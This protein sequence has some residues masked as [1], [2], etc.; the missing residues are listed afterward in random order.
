MQMNVYIISLPFLVL[1]CLTVSQIYPVHSQL[2]GYLWPFIV[3]DIIV[4]LI[5]PMIVVCSIIPLV[6]IIRYVTYAKLE[7]RRLLLWLLPFLSYEKGKKGVYWVLEDSFYYKIHGDF[8]GNLSTALLYTM[9]GLNFLFSWVYFVDDVFIDQM[10][11][12]NCNELTS[13]QKQNLYC[14]NIYPTSVY[15]NCT[16]NATY[17]GSL[18]CFEFKQ[19]G[20]NINVLQ[21]LVISVALYY[22][23]VM[24]TSLVLQAMKLLQKY[25][26]SFLW[27]A[28]IVTVGFFV[29]IYG[30]VHFASA[31][32]FNYYLNVLTLFQVL[33]ASVNIAVL[34]ILVAGGHLMQDKQQCYSENNSTN[35]SP[36]RIGLI[37]NWVNDSYASRRNAI[38]R[39][40]V[41]PNRIELISMTPIPPENTYSPGPISSHDGVSTF[42]GPSPHP[43]VA[44]SSPGPPTPPL[45]PSS[46]SNPPPMSAAPPSSHNPPQSP[47]SAQSISSS[48]TTTTNPAA[49]NNDN[50]NETSLMTSDNL[51]TQEQQQQQQQQQEDDERESVSHNSTIHQMTEEPHYVHA[52]IVDSTSTPRQLMTPSTSSVSNQTTNME[53]LLRASNRRIPPAANYVTVDVRED[54][55]TPPTIPLRVHNDGHPASQSESPAGGRK[56]TIV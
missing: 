16:A 37:E 14:F 44:A 27:P 24:L 51:P 4:A 54:Y 35:T 9:A 8:C 2:E 38:Y 53:T 32:Y 18:F 50:I 20:R 48:L 1:W 5:S 34:G 40:R 22:I 55:M 47:S 31:V 7:T 45:S 52:A 33:I 28:L 17:S 25:T 56:I 15:M 21:S 42:I 39:R 29:F 49:Q 30:L 6:K 3:T 26:Q 11:F 13:A 19:V 12:N 46:L 41:V 36:S 10:G 23:S 43:P